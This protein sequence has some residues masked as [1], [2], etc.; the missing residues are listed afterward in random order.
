MVLCRP[1]VATG[2]LLAGL[3]VRRARDAGAA[4]DALAELRRDVGDAVVLVQ[5]TLY[6]ELDA[7][8]LKRD[9]GALLVVPFPDPAWEE[10]P[11]AAEE[12]LVEMLRRAVGYRVR[13]R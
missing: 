8:Q 4:A 13:L 5:D 3:D 7:R 2:F 12:Y 1:E 6:D 9:E 10:E 11:S